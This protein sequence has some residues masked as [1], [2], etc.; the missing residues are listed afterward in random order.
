MS[1]NHYHFQ[2]EMLYDL[3]A[4]REI[5]KGVLLFQ[6][7]VYIPRLIVGVVLLYYF[8]ILVIFRTLF[9]S[10]FLKYFLILSAIFI[11]SQLIVYFKIRSGGI[12][13]KRMLSGNNGKPVWNLVSFDMSGLYISNLDTGN[14]NTYHYEQIRSLAHTKNYLMLQLEYRQYIAVRKDRLTGGTPDELANYLITLCPKVKPRRVRS[15]LPGYLINWFVLVLWILT[16]LLALYQLPVVQNLI[17]STKPINNTMSYQEI[18]DELEPLGIHVDQ[19]IIDELEEFS[20]STDYYAYGDGYSKVMDL[21]CYAGYGSYDETTW[22]WTPSNCGVYWFD[23]E[24]WNLDS[25]YSDFLRGVSALNPQELDFTNIQ[26]DISKVNWEEGSGVQSAS[27]DWNGQTYFLGGHVNY[28]WFDTQAADDLNRIIHAQTGK[29]L[30]FAYDGGQGFLVFY[31][32]SEWAKE[33][34][35]VTDVSIAASTTIFW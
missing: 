16:L 32:T 34:K 20:I 35:S 13:Y 10:A 11:V 14:I 28:D 22:E 1:E 9:D 25:M 3:S 21:L 7:Q 4:M 19:E 15:C 31:G 24:V 23:M 26:E 33:F 5:N 30:Y 29:N 17:D 8:A 18:A 2:G 6:P 27:F 12:H